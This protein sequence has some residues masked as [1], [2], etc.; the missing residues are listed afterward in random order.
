MALEAQLKDIEAE[1]RKY[2]DLTLSKKEESVQL[3]EL[4]KLIDAEENEIEA[5]LKKTNDQRA[6]CLVKL[7][8][9]SASQIQTKITQTQMANPASKNDDIK[10]ML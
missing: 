5:A 4:Q 8:Q 6:K 7:T 2:T 1:E 9:I 10:R 3:K